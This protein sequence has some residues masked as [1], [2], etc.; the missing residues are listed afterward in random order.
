MMKALAERLDAPIK[1]AEDVDWQGDFIEAQC[2]AYL[3][4]R[5][6]KKLPLSFPKTTN[7]PSPLTGGHYHKGRG[8]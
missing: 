1:T 6:L 7:V 5:S 3:A 4:I 8:L 2:F